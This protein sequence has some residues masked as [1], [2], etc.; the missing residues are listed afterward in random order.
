MGWGDQVAKESQEGQPGPSPAAPPDRARDFIRGTNLRRILSR[1]LIAAL[2]VG[3]VCV[4]LVYRLRLRRS[5]TPVQT[6]EALPQ[7]AQQA[8]SGFVHTQSEGHHPVFTIRAKRS[9]EFKGKEGTTLEGVEVEIFGRNGDRHDVVSTNSC[10][11]E[12]DS[13]D[14]FCAGPVEIELNAP[15]KSESAEPGSEHPA[16]SSLTPSRQPIYLETS[17]LA[18]NQQ[19][20][21]A[22]TAEPVKWRYGPASGSA[23]G[24]TYAARDQWIE[25]QHDVVV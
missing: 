9:V 10:R 25:L 24:L 7:D 11:Y 4:F 17:G 2:L 14:F 20:A 13:G 5:E 18:Y 6:P 23:T 22:T 1:A 21:M 16:A 19:R 15:R 3:C 8:A 12:S